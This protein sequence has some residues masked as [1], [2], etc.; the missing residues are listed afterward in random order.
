MLSKSLKYFYYKGLSTQ[1]HP[2][3]FVRPSRPSDPPL[4]LFDAFHKKYASSSTT[5]THL[6][7][8]S[9]Q[10]RQD[11]INI[12][13]KIVE[14]VG[15]EKIEKQLAEL[16]E[17][18]IVDLDGMRV[19]GLLHRPWVEGDERGDG[20]WERERGKLEAMGLKVRE[21]DLGRGLLE[22]WEDARGISSALSSLRRLSVRRVTS[23]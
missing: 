16:T 18:K 12:S 22:R 8:T 13:G 5:T 23:S 17:L 7:A 2:A 14:E 21:L 3:S 9:K 6:P 19:G 10:N 20:E 15:F 11:E 4:S 1:P